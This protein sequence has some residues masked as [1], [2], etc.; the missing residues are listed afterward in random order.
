MSTI[1][2]RP[3]M[4]L[5]AVGPRPKVWTVSEFNQ[6]GDLGVFEGQRAM[7]IDGVI[8]EEG[9]MNPPHRIA[10]ELATEAIRIA[11]GSGWR[12]C[13]QMPL[14]LGQTS[15]P[16]PDIAL[17]PGSSRGAIA[18]PTTASLVIE[19]SD[20]SL[21][22]DTTDKMSLYAAG[23]IADYWVLD[24]VGRQLIVHRDPQPDSAQH[25]RFG[26]ASITAFGPTDSVAA[27]A[28][29]TAVV[30]VAEMLP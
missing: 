22:Y 15:D 16:E 20:T 14:H 18:H 30:R 23:G 11:F 6:L 9:P 29:L 27:L 25:F 17:I 4:P 13:V 7:L 8:I 21:R 12:V 28:Q 10:L 2:T 19:V 5:S 26:Y 1:A 24:V 3:S